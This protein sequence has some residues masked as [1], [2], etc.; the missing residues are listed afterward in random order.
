MMP[1]GYVVY[2]LENLLAKGRL[3]SEGGTY[4]KFNLITQYS[5]FEG[6]TSHFDAY[7]LRMGS[8]YCLKILNCREFICSTLQHKCLVKVTMAFTCKLIKTALGV[9][10]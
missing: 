9:T 5:A 3:G 4:L 1:L 7:V 8:D 10:T 2:N 6:P